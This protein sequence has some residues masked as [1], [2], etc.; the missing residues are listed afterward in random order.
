MN[1]LRL[2]LLMLALLGAGGFLVWVP[3][4][5]PGERVVGRFE[6]S[7]VGRTPGQVANAKLCASK[8]RGQTVAP[9]ETFSFNTVLGGWTRDQGYRKAPVSYNGQLVSA[10]G[11]GVCQVSTTLYN[12]ALLAGMDVVQ[13]HRHQFAPDYAP[14]GRDAA[15]AYDD[16]DLRLRNPH[17]FAVRFE[18]GIRGD[19]LWVRVLGRGEVATVEIVS[20]VREVRQPMTFANGPATGSARVRCDGKPGFEVAVW[21]IK[22]GRRQLVSADD[23]PAM[24]RLVEYR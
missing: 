17:P 11:G 9:G 24:H 21:R 3:A 12:A 7:L 4:S 19:R 14:P 8:I 18:S 2:G 22:G 10:W 6:T 5:A 20:E 16:V 23:Y 15:V 13:R 1:A